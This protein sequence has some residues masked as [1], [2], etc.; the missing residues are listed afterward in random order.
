MKTVNKSTTTEPSDTKKGIFPIQHPDTVVGK[1]GQ[2]VE[3]Y[4]LENEKRVVSKRG[5]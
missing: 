4:V 5:M 3:W 2:Y 1:L